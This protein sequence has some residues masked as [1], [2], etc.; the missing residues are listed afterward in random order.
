[1]NKLFNTFGNNQN[2]MMQQFMQFKNSFKG[3]AREQVQQLLNSGKI[4]QEQYDNAVKMAN[5]FKDLLK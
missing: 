3:D 4:T 1:M 5:Q 2:P